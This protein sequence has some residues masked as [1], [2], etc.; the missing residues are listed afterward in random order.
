MGGMVHTILSDGIIEGGF[1]GV[2]V[3]TFI[4]TNVKDGSWRGYGAGKAGEFRRS[5]EPSARVLGLGL[6]WL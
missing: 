4:I 1:G 6:E 3:R 5:P 2:A